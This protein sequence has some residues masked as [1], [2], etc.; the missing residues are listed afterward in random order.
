MRRPAAVAMLLSGILF[1]PGASADIYRYV[2]SD[3]KVH[4][5][6]VPENSRYRIHRRDD[7]RNPITN[8]F[9]RDVNFYSPVIRNR[10]DKYIEAAAREQ[11]IDPA[12]VHAVISAESGYN[13]IARSRSGAAGLMQLMPE[14][15]RRFGARNR[16][17]PV[18]NIQAGVRYLRMLMD[19]FDNDLELVIAAYNAGENAVIRAGHRIPPYAET[20]TYVPRVLEY[21][22]RYRA[23]L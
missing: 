20:M 12:L 11:N 5:T 9:A 13:P 14:T 22:R 23:Q 3:G 8:T 16:F 18:E 15:A 17:N 7:E 10:Y 21:Y 2:D 1:A 19:L 6:N 4:Y